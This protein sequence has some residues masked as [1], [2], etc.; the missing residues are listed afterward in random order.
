MGLSETGTPIPG[1]GIRE[2]RGGRG[3]LV[4]PPRDDQ[5]GRLSPGPGKIEPRRTKEGEGTQ[6]LS[7]D[8]LQIEI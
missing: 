4:G 2:G 7:V 8:K 3:V 6:S 5:G 1:K